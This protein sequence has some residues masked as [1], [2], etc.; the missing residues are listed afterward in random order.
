MSPESTPS[1]AASKP[2]P[3]S[4]GVR[5]EAP[6]LRG[7]ESYDDVEA[8]LLG[9]LDIDGDKLLRQRNIRKTRSTSPS[10]R[11]AAQ[12]IEA[13]T[14]PRNPSYVS[15]DSDGASIPLEFSQA[16]I[17]A[18]APFVE[19][20]IMDYELNQSAKKIQSDKQTE[21]EKRLGI[22]HGRQ[23]EYPDTPQTIEIEDGTPIESLWGRERDEHS[24]FLDWKVMDQTGTRYDDFNG[25]VTIDLDNPIHNAEI[26]QMGGIEQAA[27]NTDDVKESRLARL[28]R[29]I[30]KR[31]NTTTETASRPARTD[32]LD[33]YERFD[34]F[35]NATPDR[36]KT[37]LQE[38]GKS[39]LLNARAIN[40]FGLYNYIRGDLNVR[41]G[42]SE[43]SGQKLKE[44]FNKLREINPKESLAKRS[45]A[46]LEA[47]GNGRET[48][49]K[50]LKDNAD[51]ARARRDR[52]RLGATT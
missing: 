45:K 27:P 4:P 6:V 19:Q 47:I 10:A 29:L 30:P 11:K 18:A 43:E 22:F 41:E 31:E 34:A 37:L 40:M 23:I 44:I 7:S 21:E 8:R 13:V 52:R 26:P 15:L 49:K 14:D 3:G 42:Y 2:K 24:D 16:Q 38:T 32:E 1:S 46:A 12:K 5:S 51:K 35:L 48:L 25:K 20:M 9:N 28:A 33:V 50:L 36:M 39:A 17:D